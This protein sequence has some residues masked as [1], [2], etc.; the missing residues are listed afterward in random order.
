VDE[1]PGA[2]VADSPFFVLDVDETRVDPRF[3]A[4]QINQPRPQ[5]W[6]ARRSRGTR[7][8]TLRKKDLGQLEIRLPD[9]NEQRRAAD[10]LS[11]IRKQRALMADLQ[12]RYEDL[13][14][15]LLQTLI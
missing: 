3:L 2:A 8:P 5:N 1:I 12:S 11:L 10:L 14:R 4:L 7:M 9:M 15:G 13:V 6:L